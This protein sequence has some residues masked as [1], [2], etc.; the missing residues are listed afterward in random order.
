MS[1]SPI[2]AVAIRQRFIRFKVLVVRLHKYTQKANN[3]LLVHQRA[4]RLQH[5]Q[6][7]L[8]LQECFWKNKCVR[9]ELLRF[10]L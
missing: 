7:L 9:E 5:L 8:N 10:L 4:E 3:R 1:N 6:Q 2:E